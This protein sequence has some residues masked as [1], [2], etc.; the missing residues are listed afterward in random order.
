[1]LGIGD[2]PMPLLPLHLDYQGIGALHLLQFAEP[3]EARVKDDKNGQSG[4][5]HEPAYC[6]RLAAV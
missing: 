5:D 6:Y 4:G 3:L 2:I 1:M